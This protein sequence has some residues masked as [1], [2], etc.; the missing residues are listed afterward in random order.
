MRR[1]G[2]SNRLAWRFCLARRSQKARFI[3]KKR[4]RRFFESPLQEREAFWR[5]KRAKTPQKASKWRR[6]ERAKATERKGRKGEKWKEKLARETG[7][8]SKFLGSIQ[9]SPK[10]T[11]NFN[12][13]RPRKWSKPRL[14]L[15]QIPEIEAKQAKMDKKVHTKDTDFLGVT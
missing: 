4:R 7:R 5:A 9:E 8:T 6:S 13:N 12:Q 14:K 15:D 11:S 1:S 3:P 2:R 10:S